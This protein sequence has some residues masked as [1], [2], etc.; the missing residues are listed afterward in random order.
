MIQQQD[1]IFSKFNLIIIGVFFIIPFVFIV[2]KFSIWGYSYEKILPKTSYEITLNL[3]ANSYGDNLNIRTY[4]PVNDSRQMIYDEMVNSSTLVHKLEINEFGREG[5]WSKENADGQ[6]DISYSFS[7]I[8]KA[9]EYNIDS[10]LHIAAAYS[11]ALT[12]YL[13]PTENIQSNHPFIN[14]LSLE[15]LNNSTQIIGIL[16]AIFNYTHSLDSKPFK[17]LTDAVTAAKLGEASCN[18]KS[19]LFVALARNIGIPSRLIGGIILTEGTKKTSHQWVEVYINGYW[20]PFDP[21]NGHFAYIPNNYLSLYTGDAFLFAHTANINFDYSFTVKNRLV[22]NP[23][24]VDELHHTPFNAYKVWK[25]FERV[26]IPLGLLK[27]IIM[28]P[29]GALFVAIFRNVIG[30]QTFGIFLPALIAL[31]SRET[32]LFYGLIGFIIVAGIVSLLH[33][34]L[35]KLGILYVPKMTILLISVVITFLIT[36]VIA[37]NINVYELSYVS[38]FPIVIVTITAEQFGRKITEDGLPDALKLIGQTLLVS[39]VA[40]FA[41]NSRTMESF[42]LAFPELLLIILGLNLMLGRWIGLRLTEYYRFR[43]LLK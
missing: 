2:L 27:L 4:F 19:R 36:S 20:V 12:K 6:F 7:F 14:Q 34:P 37:I 13:T 23:T 40:Y 42:F 3:S 5:N 26:G 25:G 21:L 22:A 30:I 16:H 15:K 18:G 39:A 28:L 1:S 17:G 29:L 11:S 31:S 35:N 41:M 32:G 10:S 24:L 8:G 33:F 43:W 9:I 38:L